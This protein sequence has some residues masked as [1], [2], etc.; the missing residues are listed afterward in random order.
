MSSNLR[1]LDSAGGF[2][3]ENSIL[4][5]KDKNLKNINSVELQNSF[6]ADAKISQYILRG[7]NTSIL[8]L[9]DVGSQII[10]PSNTINFITSKI[11]AVN[12]SGTG[13]VCEKIESSIDVSTSGVLTEL[14]SML[15]IIKSTIPSSEDWSIVPFTSG[16][17]NRFSYSTTR[18]GSTI[19][20]K[21]I[22]FTEVVSISWI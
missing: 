14:S 6:F 17:L 3:V 2:S 9:D 15:T 10:L 20:V 12:E 16:S 4:I 18:S 7:A 22:V 21:W 1:T 19:T 8:S 5:D 11:V 13:T